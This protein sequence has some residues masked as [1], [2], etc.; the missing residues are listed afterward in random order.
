MPNLLFLLLRFYLRVDG[1]LVRTNDTRYF[2]EAGMDHMLREFCS[3][4]SH[5]PDLHVSGYCLHS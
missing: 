1:V 3:K 4:E 2:L 5:I